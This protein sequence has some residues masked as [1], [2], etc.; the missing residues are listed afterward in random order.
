M[1]TKIP[2]TKQEA[3]AQLDEMLSEEVDDPK[4]FRAKK[5]IRGVRLHFLPES[6]EGTQAL[7]DGIT[8]ERD[9]SSE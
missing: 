9:K 1:E 2:Q 3:F 7:Y 5:H 6:Y 4:T 8:F